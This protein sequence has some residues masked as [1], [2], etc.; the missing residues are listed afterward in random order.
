MKISTRLFLL[1]VFLFLLNNAVFSQ[2]TSIVLHSYWIVNDYGKSLTIKKYF[3]VDNVTGDTSNFIKIAFQDQRVTNNNGYVYI[4]SRDMLKQFITD[5]E[6]MITKI[7]KGEFFEITKST[8]KLDISN[9]DY[10]RLFQ[11]NLHKKVCLHE[12][13]SSTFIGLKEDKLRMIIDDLKTL[14]WE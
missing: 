10:K 1:T 6:N 11:N 5:L 8:Y 14:A 4:L 3:Q 2:N 12:V 7:D 13:N 9:P